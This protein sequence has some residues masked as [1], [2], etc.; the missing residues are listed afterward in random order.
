MLLESQTL[1]ARTGRGVEKLALYVA[2][3][4]GLGLVFITLI[5]LAN[6]VGRALVPFGLTSVRGQIELVQAGTAF[7]ICAFLPWAHL[8]R[9]HASVAIFTDMLG[10]RTNRVIDLV[11]DVV[12]FALAW[13]I[14]WQHTLGMFDKQAFGETTFLL[15]LPLWWAYAACLIGLGAWIIVGLWASINSAHQMFARP[16]V[17]LKG[18]PSKKHTDK[19]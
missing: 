9:G 11:G 18:N 6:V 10:V 2:I 12:L 15:R 14:T 13:L 16:P 8:K 17:K 1:L 5:T 4:G 7:A 3:L 19:T